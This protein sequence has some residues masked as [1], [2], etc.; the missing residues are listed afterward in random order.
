[1]PHAS[2]QL[3][4]ELA[5]AVTC[6]ILRSAQQVHFSYARQ[7]EE[8][9][10]RPSRIVT[11]L[12]GQ[13]LP[14]PAELA[15]PAPSAPLTESIEDS[16][17]IPFPGGAVSGGASV[18][19]AQS[20]CP[21]KAFAVERLGAS[22]WEAAQTGL[23]AQQRGSLVHRVLESIWGGP[24]AGIR[25]SDELAKKVAS[26]LEEF[27]AGHVRR[28][29]GASFLAATRELMPARYL[30][31]EAQRL[32]GLIAEWLR[33]EAGRQ[34]F[35]VSEA[36]KKRTVSVEGLTLTVR[37]D[38]LDRL[39]DGSVLVVDYKTGDAKP[40]VWE[41]PRPEDVQLPL[42]ATLALDRVEEPVGG[43]VF[44]K[45]RPGE[46]GFA[47]R[48]FDATGTLDSALG[49]RTALAKNALELEDLEDWR[50]AIEQLAR[51]FLAGKATVDPRDYPT[52]CRNC[53][54]EALC[55][56]R[57]QER[58]DEEDEPEAEEGEDA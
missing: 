35:D 32:T 18:L 10:R 38:R 34:P 55:R 16:S 44:A 22:G 6:R 24:P 56:V 47:G 43:L 57:E 12:A 23:T 19:T 42:Y 20:N 41:L 28:A 40:K 50:G 17:R 7:G 29:M 51:E 45:V 52:T 30:E 37:P 21:F 15:P 53:G 25:T 11:G 48:L 8:G 58:L 39:N 9:Q 49:A 2:A 3:D 54:L 46:M 5:S 33:L 4:W 14:L 27:V 36:E 26:G 1:M 13:P 31:L